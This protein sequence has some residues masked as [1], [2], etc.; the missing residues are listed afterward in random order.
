MQVVPCSI[1]LGCFDSVLVRVT[2]FVL[3]WKRPFNDQS[4]CFNCNPLAASSIQYIYCNLD[5]HWRTEGIIPLV[6]GTAIRP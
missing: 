3:C 6:I 2:L 4:A 5:V 1:N